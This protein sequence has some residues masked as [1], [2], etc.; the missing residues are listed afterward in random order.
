MDSCVWI[1]HYELCKQ[2]RLSQEHGTNPTQEL[3][4][5]QSV[6]PAFR[7]LVET[8][9]FSTLK[10]KGTEWSLNG[11]KCISVQV[12]HISKHSFFVLCDLCFLGPS[13]SVL[14]SND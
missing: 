3:S 11:G 7:Q 13:I 10:A 5:Y 12:S 8:L 4:S 9:T 14:S 1:M 2:Q 6:I